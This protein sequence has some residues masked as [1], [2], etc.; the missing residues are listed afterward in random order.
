MSKKVSK[1]KKNVHVVDFST[2]DNPN[3]SLIPNNL[4]EGIQQPE[5]K[6]LFFFDNR[7]FSFYQSICQLVY[8][9]K[10]AYLWTLPSIQAFVRAFVMHGG[11]KTHTSVEMKCSGINVNGSQVKSFVYRIEG[12]K[13][14]IPTILQE[15]KFNNGTK[16]GQAWD[17]HQENLFVTALFAYANR[18]QMIS[19]IFHLNGYNLSPKF[20]T[21]LVDGRNYNLTKLPNFK[22]IGDQLWDETNQLHLKTLFE[23]DPSVST[24][25]DK[26]LSNHGITV[27]SK[28]IQSQLLKQGLKL[29]KVSTYS[30]N[31]TSWSKEE[32]SIV[33]NVF[34]ST[35]KNK[36]SLAVLILSKY[37]EA[38]RT[39]RSC[40]KQIN[41]DKSIKIG[42]DLVD[43]TDENE[44]E[45]LDGISLQPASN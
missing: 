34:S 20:F 14:E 4:C 21:N 12:A 5:G 38:I 41:K 11:N 44:E 15:V 1:T 22:F 19:N 42:L 16:V 25:R 7:M 28:Q 10:D 23:D 9:G 32:L 13:I 8:S 3:I 30:R 40:K 43:Y 6:V 35:Y 31:V 39:E 37:F 17:E 24:I 29:K 36:A 33:K 27:T 26:L 2:L 18:P 45:L